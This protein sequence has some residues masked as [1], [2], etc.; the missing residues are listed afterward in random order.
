MFGLRCNVR[1]L[2]QCSGVEALFRYLF[3]FHLLM[4]YFGLM[5]CLGVAALFGFYDMFGY[6]CNVWVLIQYY[7][8]FM[9]YL[10]VNA[11]PGVDTIF[12]C[13]YNIQVFMKFL[14]VYEI[15]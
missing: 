14:G 6:E 2:M 11:I 15:F 7:C 4:R 8:V 9:K 10:S 3:N 13:S 1:V 12:E 5:Q